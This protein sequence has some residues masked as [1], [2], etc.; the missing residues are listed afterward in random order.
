MTDVALSLTVDYAQYPKRAASM[1][2]AKGTTG[3]DRTEKKMDAWSKCL[4]AVRDE[5]DSASFAR[6]FQHFGPR[7]KSFLISKGASDGVAEEAMQEA[8]ATVWFKARLFDPARASAS[9]WIFTI[10]RNKF[11]DSIRKTNRPEP[12]DVD[13]EG[14]APQEPM[15]LVAAAEE[16]KLV[17]EAIEQLPDGQKEIVQKAFFGDLSHSEIAALTG[18]PLGTIK[19]R[20]RLGLERM[21]KELS[22]LS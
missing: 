15:E 5:E 3:V 20:I 14:E 13:W 11:L 18:L 22:V 10:A 16:A 19:S 21:R 7:V 17:K 4:I 6:L 12:E 2:R 8:M 1:L 9:T